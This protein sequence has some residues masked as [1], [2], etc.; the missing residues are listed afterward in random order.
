MGRQT[1]MEALMRLVTEPPV[2]GSDNPLALPLNENPFSPLPAVHATIV[3]A[4]GTANRYPEFLPERLR[5]VI[6]QHLGVNDEQIVI[7]RRGY[8][9]GHAGTARSHRPRRPHCDD[10]S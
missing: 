3:A 6:A 5:G 9:R 1:L 10:I 4:V 7:G 2:H 8:R